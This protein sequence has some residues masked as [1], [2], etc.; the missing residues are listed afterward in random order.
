MRRKRET[1]ELP[2]VIKH[3]VVQKIAKNHHKSPAQVLLRWAV[4]R[5]TVVLPKSTHANRIKENIDIFDFELTRKE[6]NAI[7]KLDQHGKY[8]KFDFRTFAG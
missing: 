5:K 7:K 4:Q 2:T 1:A 8:R 3:P 6:M